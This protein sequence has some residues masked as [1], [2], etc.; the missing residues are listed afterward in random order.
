[1]F[2]GESISPIP[3]KKCFTAPF[4]RSF[5][6]S[7]YFAQ[8]GNSLNSLPHSCLTLLFEL[9]P[10]LCACFLLT[11]VFTILSMSVLEISSDLFA[12]ASIVDVFRF[13]KAVSTYPGEFFIFP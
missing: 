7:L 11:F 8:C 5:F 9:F 4:K 2:N 1:M 13:A 10:K 12:I 6:F 3:S